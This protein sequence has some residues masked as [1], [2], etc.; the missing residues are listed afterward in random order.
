MKVYIR[1]SG[2]SKILERS[3]LRSE[4]SEVVY[5]EV[6]S[7]LRKIGWWKHRVKISLW[8][9][10]CR[11]IREKETRRKCRLHKTLPKIYQKLNRK[12]AGA[13]EFI[14]S[15]LNKR[16][17]DEKRRPRSFVGVNYSSL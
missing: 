10:L 9:V 12:R 5:V 14:R 8:L 11:A 7:R 6:E 1:G 3:F 4:R 15:F 13:H 2:E 16:Q 17:T